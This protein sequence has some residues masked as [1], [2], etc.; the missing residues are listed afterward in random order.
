MAPPP[1]SRRR[2]DGAQILVTTVV[3]LAVAV[4]GVVTI[5]LT[6]S[7][8]G[9]AVAL[10]AAVAATAMMTLRF[11]D[12]VGDGDDEDSGS[13]ARRTV[14][15]AGT[16][17]AG[18]LI[19]AL[20]LAGTVAAQQRTRPADASTA[21]QTLRDFLTVGVL[22]NNP[23]AACQYLTPAEQHAVALRGGAY[24]NCRDVLTANPPRFGTLDSPGQLRGLRM[25]T[26]VHG[27]AARVTVSGAGAAPRT[28]VLHRATA[29]DYAAY[30]APS[31]DW[32]V[33]SGATSLL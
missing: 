9:L 15:G 24:Q 21:T 14:L 8:W 19:L 17:A 7:F 30:L 25:Q 5:A 1:R 20:T 11:L 12:V 18:V 27:D 33:A 31:A 28:F 4:A 26:V 6:R 22:E 23:Y 29:A 32:R 13:P 2:R 3:L 10:V 16:F